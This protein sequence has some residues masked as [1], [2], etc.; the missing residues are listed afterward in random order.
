[1]VEYQ[2]QRRAIIERDQATEWKAQGLCRGLDPDLFFPEKGDGGTTS[3]AHIA[4]A[5][6]DGCPVKEPCAE[7]GTWEYF[8]IWGGQ[9]NKV[10]QKKR[11]Q[12]NEQRSA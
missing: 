2:F 7:A 10:R 5:I 1:M 9:T 11:R 8:G 6:C 12:I 3:S 4:Q